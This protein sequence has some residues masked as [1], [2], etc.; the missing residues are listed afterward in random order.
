[1]FRTSRRL[2]L[3]DQPKRLAF[4]DV[5]ASSDLWIIEIFDAPV[6]HL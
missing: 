2:G 1:M 5:L 3:R 4:V 6:A